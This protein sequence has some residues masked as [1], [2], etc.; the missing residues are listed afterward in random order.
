MTV[1]F[2]SDHHIGHKRIREIS[3]RP[4]DSDEEMADEIIDRHNSVVKP[5]DTTYFLGDFALG[6]WQAHVPYASRFNGRRVLVSGNHDQPFIHR[7]K[8][9]FDRVMAGYLEHFD[10]VHLGSIRF[11][12]YVLSHFPYDGAD[13]REERYLNDRPVDKGYTLCHGHVH[14]EDPGKQITRSSQ[15]TLQV[16]VGVDGRNFT[17]VSIDEINEIWRNHG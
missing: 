15:G 4:F 11:G 5:G 10:E 2:A 13:E 7:G 16:H 1:W 6:G 17:P 9:S 12:R 8:P 3:H 14:Q